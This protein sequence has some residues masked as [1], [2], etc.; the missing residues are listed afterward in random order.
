M[1][2]FLFPHTRLSERA[3]RLRLAVVGLVGALAVGS[4]VMFLGLQTLGVLSGDVRVQ[5]RLATVGDTLGINSDVKYAGLRVGRVVSV[6]PGI[7]DPT[8]PSAEVLVASDQAVHIPALVRARVLPGTL[9]G[10]EY[11]DLVVPTRDAG[12]DG[13]LADGDVVAA[14]TSRRTL[15]LMATLSA[16]QRLL[17]AVDPAQWDR[18]LSELAGALDGRGDNIRRFVGDADRF[19]MRWAHTEPQ[20]MEDLDLLAR[21]ADTLTDVEPAFVSTLEDTLPLTRTLVAHRDDTV[22]LLT[23]TSR[24]LDGPNGVTAFLRDNGS[25]VAGLLNAT[26]ATLEVFAQRHP[27]F[28][29]LLGKLPSVLMNGARAVKD[30]RIQMEGVLAPQL[31]DP[32]DA[33]DCPR[34]GDLAGPNCPGGR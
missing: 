31:L 33:S 32:Y 3:L 17:G 26:A 11:V 28:E 25:A 12:A 9:F 10:N 30:G 18:A 14:D 7:D 2:E 13:H 24:L 29:A 4:Y 27:A 16:T 20:V 23:G 6:D 22:A 5:V 15:R 8:G 21:N 1:S 19:L 34:Y